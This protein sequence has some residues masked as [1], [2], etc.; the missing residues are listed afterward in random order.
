MPIQI[1]DLR[2]G[3]WYWI[4]KEVI[5]R[6]GARLG[7]YGIAIYNVLAL[8]AHSKTQ[9]C[10][11]SQQR[12]ADTLGCSRRTVFLYLKKLEKLRL[13]KLER[14]GRQ[15]RIYI[16]LRCAPDSHPKEGKCA[17]KRISDVRQLPINN[18]TLTRI[19]V[20]RTKFFLKWANPV[21]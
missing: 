8:F 5:L 21:K 18:N 1:R 13:V 7:P 3:D 11:P 2:D 17:N 19:S 10:Y 12:I 4:H 20:Y 15:G 9:A 14:K 16:L 6:F